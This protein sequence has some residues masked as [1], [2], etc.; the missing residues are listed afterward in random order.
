MLGDRRLR[1]PELP[2]DDIAD[3]ARGLL[4]LGEQLQD[5][6]AHG[7]S[8]HIESVHEH[9]RITSHLYKRPVIDDS[10]GQTSGFSS[11]ALRWLNVSIE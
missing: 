10:A 2:P 3:R 8:E 7:V 11:S 4:A 1:Y 5:A 6:A 9:Q